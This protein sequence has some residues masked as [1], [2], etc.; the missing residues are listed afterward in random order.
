MSQADIDFEARKKALVRR[1][2]SIKEEVA[3]SNRTGDEERQFLSE[4]LAELK[5]TTRLLMEAFTAE[6]NRNYRGVEF[7]HEGGS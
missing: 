3:A 5:E 2:D 6:I 7:G 1:L 4:K